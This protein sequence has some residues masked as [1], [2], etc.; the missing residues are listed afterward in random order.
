MT[1]PPT[2]SL[3]NSLPRA[4]REDDGTRPAEAVR[5]ATTAPLAATFALDGPH[6]R[7][8]LS[9]AP[10]TLD[11]IA[12]NM[13]DRIL[14]KDHASPVACGVYTVNERDITV[15]DRAADCLGPDLAPH[16]TVTVLEGPLAGTLWR[17]VGPH[18]HVVDV[19]P[20]TFESVDPRSLSILEALIRTL[21]GELGTTYAE[22][23]DL[24]GAHDPL[25]CEPRFLVELAADLG[26][27]L[28]T[29]MPLAVQRKLVAAL[30]LLYRRKGTR[31]GIAALLRL[32][33][34]SEV[35]VRAVR[36]SGWRLGR[37]RL[38]LRPLRFIATGGETTFDITLIVPPADTP[39]GQYR[40]ETFGELV[41]ERN[42]E[43]LSRAE[44]R[45]PDPRTV[46]L[47]RG[48]RFVVRAGEQTLTLTFDAPLGLTELEIFWNGEPIALTPDAVS[49]PAPNQLT[50]TSPVFLTGDV[51]EVRS[52]VQTVPLAAG[53]VLW[54][55]VPPAERTRLSPTLPRPW[56]DNPSPADLA[57]YDRARTL[58]V[59]VARRLV[60]DGTVNEPQ[61]VGDALATMASSTARP[62]LRAPYR[63]PKPKWILGKSRLGRDT[64]C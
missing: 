64:R 29:R 28:D 30:V 58:L 26:W 39:E 63:D 51:V 33:T 46:V 37:A 7:G 55:R 62:V 57:A 2:L 23:K 36:A 15:W 32:V 17:L 22:I 12:L 50:F 48:T 56:P 41:V 38:G 52:N 49:M 19:E 9:G 43:R 14:V 61:T 27:R 20:L 16:L 31:P 4:W 59:D 53:D 60:I 21:D 34:G 45:Q 44:A 40:A 3:W 47:C 54:I 25:T 42:G 11:G 6:G 1:A 24:A 8:R 13:G 18:A 5:I 35:R 10:S